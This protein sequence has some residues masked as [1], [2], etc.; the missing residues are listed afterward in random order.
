MQAGQQGMVT[1]AVDVYALGKVL[2]WMLSGGHI[3][4]RE[5]H[6]A[7]G[8]YLVE[9]LGDQR[10]E[11]VHIFLDTMLRED[12]KRRVSDAP[13]ALLNTI[14]PD[15]ADMVV[16]DFMPLRPSMG[17]RCEWCGRGRYIKVVRLTGD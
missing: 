5:N 6:R 10:W 7:E 16:N 1:H 11:H 14:L 3:F 12:Y 8:V 17:L 9:R 13:L 4:A 2:Y 15:M